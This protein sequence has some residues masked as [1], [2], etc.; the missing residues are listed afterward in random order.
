MLLF[1]GGTGDEVKAVLKGAPPSGCYFI[2]CTEQA[3]GVAVSSSYHTAAE[4]I[5]VPTYYIRVYWEQLC[6]GTCEGSYRMHLQVKIPVP[7]V[8]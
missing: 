3:F 7:V 2:P 4:I 6:I 5:G 8:R 1:W